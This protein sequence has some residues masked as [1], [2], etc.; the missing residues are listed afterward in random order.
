L[1]A[2]SSSCLST[3]L[4]MSNEGIPAVYP[5]SPRE[6]KSLCSAD[7]AC[8]RIHKSPSQTPLEFD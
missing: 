5:I 3:S 7:P 8:K 4:V 6:A 1:I 2:L